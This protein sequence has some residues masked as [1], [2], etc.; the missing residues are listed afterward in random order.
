MG[1]SI[2]IVP[3]STHPPFLSAAPRLIPISS[4]TPTNLAAQLQTS[5]VGT[6][7]PQRNDSPLQG[8]LLFLLPVWGESFSNIRNQASLSWR[9]SVPFSLH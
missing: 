8:L 7:N 4:V 3:T 6:F 2:A 5:L 1:S 9:S